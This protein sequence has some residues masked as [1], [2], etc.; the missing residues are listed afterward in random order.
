[1]HIANI[2]VTARAQLANA[3]AH[4][5][6]GHKGVAAESLAELS[7]FLSKQLPSLTS[8]DNPPDSEKI[9]PIMTLT[10]KPDEHAPQETTGK[11]EDTSI[12]PE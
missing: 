6:T 5:G 7:G 2:I 4:Y 10:G 12:K 3:E 1:M 8:E 11:P 9:D